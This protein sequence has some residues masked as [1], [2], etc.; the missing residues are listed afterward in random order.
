MK[1]RLYATAQSYRSH[2]HFKHDGKTPPSKNKFHKILHLMGMK[3][4][5]KLKS[6]FHKMRI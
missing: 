4:I 6:P 2:K 3:L 1:I 5:A